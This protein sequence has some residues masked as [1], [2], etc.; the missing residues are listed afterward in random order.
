[1]SQDDTPS[2]IIQ[3]SLACVLVVHVGVQYL[4]NCIAVLVLAMQN[5]FANQYNTTTRM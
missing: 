2:I 5:I 1:M 4:N 3:F